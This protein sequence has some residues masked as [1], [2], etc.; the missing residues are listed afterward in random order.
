[1]EEREMSLGLFYNGLMRGGKRSDHCGQI[2]GY[3]Y[4]WVPMVDYGEHCRPSQNRYNL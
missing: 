4:P 1:M 2:D 3:K